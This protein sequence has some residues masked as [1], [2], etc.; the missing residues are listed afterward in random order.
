MVL[1]TRILKYWVLGPLGLVA[2]GLHSLTQPDQAGQVGF[3]IYLGFGL[4]MESWGRMK[5]N[6]EPERASLRRA[7]ALLGFHVAQRVQSPSTQDFRLLVPKTPYFQWL[8]GEQRSQ[9]VAYLDP[10][11]NMEPEQGLCTDYRLLQRL[12]SS[13]LMLPSPKSTWISIEGLI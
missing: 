9:H 5:T 3:K 6:I 11:G 12:P 13:G 1:G 4:S 10:L 7:V 8:L 2:H